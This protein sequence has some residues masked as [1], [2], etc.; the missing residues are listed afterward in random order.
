MKRRLRFLPKIQ[1]WLK[2]I[3]FTISLLSANPEVFAQSR[4]ITGTITASDGTGSI[5]GANIVIK[6][7]TNGTTTGADGKFTL[8]IDD[9]SAV[10][11]IS[12]IGY[13]I[14]EITVGAQSQIDVVLDVEVTSLAEIVVVG[15]GTQNRSDVT[16]SISSVSAKEL[17]KVPVNTVDQALQ[18]RSPGVM[19]T[20]N[21]GAPG[22]GVAVRIRG[23][24][25]FGENSPLYVVDGYPISGGLNNIN[26][27]DIATIDILK[28]ASATAI[29]GSRAANG[30]V[31]ITTKRGKGDLQITFDATTSVQKSPKQYDVLN[32]R[33]FATFVSQ[34]ATDQAFPILPEW[35][36]PSS[37]KDIDWQDQVY[38]N[39]VRQNYNVGIRG[40]SEKASAAFSFGYLNHKGVILGSDYLRYNAALNIDLSNTK[41][42]KVGASLKYSRN[43]GD[44]RFGT[45][46]DGVGILSKLAPTMTGN[47]LTNDVKGNGTY[48]YYTRNSS[49]VGGMRNV[50]YDI[51]SQDRDRISNNFLG[52]AFIEIEP[53]KNLKLRSQ[54]GINTSDN[55][56]FFFT[57]TFTTIAD[58]AR[59]YYSQ[60][61]NNSFEWLSENTISYAKEFGD[62]AIDLVAGYSA[63]ENQYRDLR[64]EGNGSVSD[65]LRDVGQII[66]LSNVDSYQRT[67]SLLS[68]FGRATYRFKDRYIVTGT[69]RRDGSS[70]FASGNRF[71]IFPSVAAAW[72]V[73]QEPFMQN[74]AFVD[75]LKIRATWGQSGNQFIDDFKYLG[76]Y[77]PGPNQNDN[78]DYVL[79]VDKA[80]VEGIVLQQLPNPEL[81]WETNTQTN[82]GFDLSMLQGRVSMSFDYYRRKSEDFLLDIEVPVQTGFPRAARN[83]GSIENKG[84]EIALSYR[85]SRNDFKWGAT[86]TITTVHNEILSFSDGLES[87]PNFSALGMPTFGTSLW[88]VFSRSEVGGPVGAFYGFE[89]NGILQTQAEIDALNANAATQNGAGTYYLFAGTE[90]GDRN[91][92][93][94]LTVDTDNDGKPD[95]ADG[96]ITEADRVIIGNPIP[97]W[98]GGLNLD[99]SY[100]NFD[101]SVFFFGSFGQD[102]LN[103]A[104][105]EMQSLAPVGGVGV[106]NFGRD[107]YKH[108]WTEENHSNEYPRA[109][110]NDVNGNGRVSDAFVEDGSFVRLRNIQIGYTLPSTVGGNFI[111]R[112]RIFVSAQNLF[113][114]TK[115]SGLD[116]EIGEAPDTNGNR[117]VTSNGLDVGNYPNPKSYS[118]GINLQ[119]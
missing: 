91:F 38:R 110:R 74:V 48:G 76:T 42:L 46:R 114:I 17:E 82:L 12:S 75:E 105:R 104:K 10:L 111:K 36:D 108:H 62:H 101:V 115:Y 118:L 30:V 109:V 61:A 32:A 69:V 8:Q 71:G 67:W 87:L 106:Q 33:E 84:V 25:S 94:Q 28:D 58:T 85:E 97:K 35:E 40:G 9:N 55:S 117:N 51:E 29:Y 92:V 90:P 113:T 31:M 26:P 70:K 52:S 41:W 20:N 93:D 88:T 66:D 14:Q 86:A 56:G 64:A 81:T 19:V 53:V 34:A 73:T 5:P 60:Y 24:G 89:T 27:T 15:Y 99:A 83:V 103:F 72:K 44:T 11:I 13:A 1:G 68:Q 107:F 37:L 95:Q 116:P 49:A 100:K 3:A 78:R 18:G 65:D 57:P 45:G 7:T 39:G 16:G 2:L 4:V 112:A 6:G 21:D 77:G 23:V 96:R 102:V 80:I 63:Q 43:D 47:P 54:F 119:F 50:V 59:N 22:S 98:F 79:G